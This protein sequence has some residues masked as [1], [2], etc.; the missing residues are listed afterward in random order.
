[1]MSA[2]SAQARVTQRICEAIKGQIAAGLLGPGARLPSTRS[3]A[4]EWGVSRT[5]VTVTVAYE[6]LIAEGYLETRR[7]ARARVAQGLGPTAV[8]SEPPEPSQLPGRLSAY[9]QR[10]VEF[11]LPPAPDGLMVADFR[12]GDLAAA[13]F[14]RLAWRR[15][16]TTALLRGRRHLR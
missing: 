9:G 3:L 1:M 7:G 12:Y 4:A 8:T 5:T 15:A 6:Q 11:A 2:T 16:V 13:D 10:L 14:P